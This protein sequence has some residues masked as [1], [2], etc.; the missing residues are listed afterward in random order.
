[1]SSQKIITKINEIVSEYLGYNTE[2]INPKTTKRNEELIHKITVLRNMLCLKKEAD[3]L[4]K[5]YTPEERSKLSLSS[6]LEQY[7]DKNKEGIA[8]I[9]KAKELLKTAYDL[10]IYIS[11][12]ISI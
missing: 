9:K 12:D 2:F 10:W 6:F 3:A 1:M 8:D 11:L 7:N 5:K 4:I